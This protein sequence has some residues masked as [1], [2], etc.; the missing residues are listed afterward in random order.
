MKKVIIFSGLPGTGKSTLTMEAKRILPM[1]KVFHLGQFAREMGVGEEERKLGNLLPFSLAKEFLAVAMDFPGHVIFDGFPRSLK[2]VDLLLEEV[3]KRSFHLELVKL[4][5]P[6]DASA[7]LEASRR[8]QMERDR[9]AG[10]ESDLLR[11]QGKLKRASESDLMALSKLEESLPKSSI[12][13][14]SASMSL[15]EV[16]RRVQEVSIS[17]LNWDQIILKSMKEA[18]ERIGFPIYLSGSSVYST[19]WGGKYGPLMEPYDRDVLSEA[20]REILQET[21]KSI[22]NEVRWVASDLSLLSKW[23]GKESGFMSPEECIKSAPLVSQALAVGIDEGKFVTVAHEDAIN[24]LADG[25]LRINPKTLKNQYGYRLLEIAEGNARRLAGKFPGLTRVGILSNLGD[26]PKGVVIPPGQLKQEVLRVE[27]KG[28]PSWRN[29]HFDNWSRGILWEI[30]E[31]ENCSFR[32]PEPRPWH[33]PSPLPN[34]LEIVR[35]NVEEA[36][37]G[38]IL[39]QEERLRLS[40]IDQPEGW[41]S[42]LHWTSTTADDAGWREWLV[43]QERSRFPIGGKDLELVFIREK[44]IS[45]EQKPTHMKASLWQHLFH[46]A[47][48]LRLDH[49]RASLKPEIIAGIRCGLLVHDIGK[50]KDSLNPGT[51]QAAGV[52]LLRSWSEWK[53]I[54]KWMTEEQ[55][56]IVDWIIRNHDIFGRFCRG[57]GEKEISFDHPDFDPESNPRYKGS[58]GLT[59]LCERIKDLEKIG[60]D[61]VVSI[62]IA[63]AVCRADYGSVPTLRW[64]LKQSQR[65][66]NLLLKFYQ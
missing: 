4:S 54:F 41:I 45:G 64:A 15:P 27:K 57:V 8:R 26:H 56:K 51:H 14:I 48:E 6:G 1:S 46:A 42:W 18:E 61:R 38:K 16:I 12:K 17:F 11:I 9:K 30:A 25:V 65:V 3:R 37:D 39:S 40:G 60:L 21:L 53:G 66:T 35:K 44:T 10:R 62:E 31:T 50:L 63:A 23:M 2:E 28:R 34:I 58:L 5:F 22:C 59:D 49:L 43:N 36:R 24:D 13:S 52:H 47:L 33:P 29:P 20:P 32:F 55:T 7:Q 19:F